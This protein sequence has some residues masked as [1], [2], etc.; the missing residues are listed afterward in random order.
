MII[1]DEKE[2][3]MEVNRSCYYKALGIKC[4]YLVLNEDNKIEIIYNDEEETL[5]NQ[6]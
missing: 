1:A 4:L 2:M 5:E 3:Y 6:K